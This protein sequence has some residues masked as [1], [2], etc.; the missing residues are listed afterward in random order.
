MRIF[1]KTKKFIKVKKIAVD[2]LLCV[3]IYKSLILLENDYYNT[4]HQCNGK[5]ME[6]A[7]LSQQR[8]NL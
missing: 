8:G 5:E 3:K 6:A 4:L 7:W 2:T 1:G